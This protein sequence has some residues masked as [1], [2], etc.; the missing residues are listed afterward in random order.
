MSGFL[1]AFNPCNFCDRLNRADINFLLSTESIIAT[2]VLLCIF[3]TLLIAL[4]SRSVIH[5]GQEKTEPSANNT[6]FVLHWIMNSIGITTLVVAIL[7]VLGYVLT[8]H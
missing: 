6:M 8:K 3:A 4:S 5:E 7:C 1:A 2:A